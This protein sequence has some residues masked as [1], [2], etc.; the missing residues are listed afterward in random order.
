MKELRILSLDGGGIRGYFTAMILKRISEKYNIDITDYFD[1][2]IG[3][4]TGSLI[5]GGIGL[6]IDIDTIVDMYKYKSEYLFGKSI[7]SSISYNGFTS[8]KYDIN[9]LRTM[10]NEGY[11]Y[12]N[13]SDLKKD[14][15]LLTTNVKSNEPVIIRS[16]DNPKISLL[17]AV[18]SS[19]SAPI[20]YEP[21]Y[22]DNENVYVDGFLWANNPSIVA[23]IEALSKDGYNKNLEDIKI[24]SIGTGIEHIDYFLENKKSRIS[25]KL[26][27]N[28]FSNTYGAYNTFI[29]LSKLILKVKDESNDM[30]LNR[31]FNEKQ[32]VRIN[33]SSNIPLNIDEID[34]DVITNIDYIFKEYINKLD[35]FFEEKEIK[36]EI[37]KDEIKYNKKK[38]KKFNI[39]NFIKKYFK[40]KK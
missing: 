25:E 4:S 27:E 20:F 18:I 23:L 31:L 35:I 2:I 16:K 21:N 3:T 13:F 1:L 38:K 36:Q 24:L 33:Y 15:I 32:Y 9:K 19:S 6:G 39:I 17:E 28:I 12:K 5:A 8:S 40:D 26:K 14:I 10:V 29:P 37:E 7:I 22:I 11:N 30:L 34:P